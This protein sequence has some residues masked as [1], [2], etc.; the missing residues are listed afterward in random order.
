[1]LVVQTA[2]NAGQT[3]S[4]TYNGVALTKIADIAHSGYGYVGLWYLVNPPAGTYN[5]VVSGAGSTY[6]LCNASSWMDMDQ[7]SPVDVFTSNN[8]SSSVFTSTITTTVDKDIHVMGIRFSGASLTNGSNTYMRS[9]A[10]GSGA[11]AD[12]GKQISPAGS[13]TLTLNGSSSTAYGLVGATFKIKSS[14]VEILNPEI[15]LNFLT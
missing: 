7:S 13:N 10:G 3:S 6:Y 8:G 4:V 15:L 14:V 9:N 5:I 1:M 11:I 2:S 12:G